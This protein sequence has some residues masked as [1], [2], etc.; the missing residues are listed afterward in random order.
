M[1]FAYTVEEYIQDVSVQEFKA[2]C[3]DV[4]RFRRLCEQCGNYNRRWSCPVFSFDPTEVWDGYSQLR[5]YMRLMRSTKPEQP[6]EAAL[7]A[8]KEEKK[9]YFDLLMAWEKATPDSLMLSA[10]TCDLC[11]DICRK[12][13]GEPC[14]HPDKLRYSI[15]ALGGNVE[16]CARRYFHTPV[17]WGRDGMAP[18]YYMLMGGLL[19]R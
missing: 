2:Q 17:L 8:L 9:K 18:D 11:G 7:A 13:L 1:E 4:E 5:L 12:A 6:M 16:E 10:G 3:I 14:C 19:L 15:E